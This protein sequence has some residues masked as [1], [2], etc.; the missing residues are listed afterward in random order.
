MKLLGALPSG[1]WK[2]GVA[3]AEFLSVGESFLIFGYLRFCAPY[4][5]GQYLLAGVYFICLLMLNVLVTEITSVKG[6]DVDSILMQGYVT[7][8]SFRGRRLL[9]GTCSDLMW[10]YRTSCSSG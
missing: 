9:L 3:S 7:T 2:Y 8:I 4:F 10:D 1:L 6:I 5:E